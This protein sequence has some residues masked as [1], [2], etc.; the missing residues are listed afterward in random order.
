MAGAGNL[1]VAR[2]RAEPCGDE[3]AALGGEHGVPARCERVS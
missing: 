2:V 1:D 3:A